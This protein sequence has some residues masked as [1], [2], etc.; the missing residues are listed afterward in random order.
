MMYIYIA[1][2][3]MIYDIYI[4]NIIRSFPLSKEVLKGFMMLPRFSLQYGVAWAEA[5]GERDDRE[6]GALK[7]LY[8]I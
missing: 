5:L 1:P 2:C 6:H 3:V 8:R 4:Y 7:F